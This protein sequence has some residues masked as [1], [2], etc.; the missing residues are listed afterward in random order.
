M[1]EQAQNI[2]QPTPQERARARLEAESDKRKEVRDRLGNPIN[3]L[4][5]LL[6]DVPI[7]ITNQVRFEGAETNEF[8]H[9]TRP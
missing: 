6:A 4:A 8:V 9:D 1:I 7:E 5:H 3:G 2:K